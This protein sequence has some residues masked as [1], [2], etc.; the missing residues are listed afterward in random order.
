MAPKA[1]RRK[2]IQ[3][4]GFEG[5]GQRQWIM[6]MRDDKETVTTMITIGGWD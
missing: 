4:D 3:D 5:R 1:M 6:V 2:R